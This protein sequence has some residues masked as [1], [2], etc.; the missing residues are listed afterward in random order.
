[1]ASFR[2]NQKAVD[3]LLRSESG[4]VGQELGKRAA[5]VQACAKRKAPVDTGRLRNSIDW[6]LRASLR[7]DLIARV[8]TN[9]HYAAHQEYGTRRGV[10]EQRYLRDCLPAAAK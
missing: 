6:E 9:V 3:R 7:T 5:K 4:P 1:M 10:P 8:G 2:L